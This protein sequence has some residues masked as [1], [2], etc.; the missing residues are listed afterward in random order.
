MDTFLENY[1]SLY[2]D[3]LRDFAS[4]TFGGFSLVYFCHLPSYV[5][6][7]PVLLNDLEN[8]S[9]I[10]IMKR[11]ASSS[12]DIQE[13]FQIFTEKHRVAPF[14]KDGKVVI[15]VD[16]LLRFPKS[17][18]HQQFSSQDTVILTNGT[19]KKNQKINRSTKPKNKTQL[20]NTAVIKIKKRNNPSIIKNMSIYYLGD[21]SINV[22]TQIKQVQQQAR[23]ILSQKENHPFIR[24]QRFKNGYSLL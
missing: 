5:L 24:N 21:F 13:M 19:S 4:L 14:K 17:N 16:K 8:E 11:K 22:E 10:N 15:T 3:F 7:N 9:Y 18:N 12:K 2:M 6:R 20:I 1:W 23:K